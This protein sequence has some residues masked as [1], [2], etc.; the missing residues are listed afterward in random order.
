MTDV[1]GTSA[2]AATSAAYGVSP[3]A[4]GGGV[5]LERCAAVIYLARLLTGASGVELHG[6]RVERISCQQAAAHRVDDL[7]ISA[8]RDDGTD[9]LELDIAVRRAPAFTTGDQDTGKL[10]GDLLAALRASH[11]E[12]VELRLAICVA[13][14]QRAAQQVSHSARSP[15]SKRPR[16]G[17]STWCARHAASSR[18]WI[19]RGSVFATASMPVLRA[20]CSGGS[21]T[22]ARSAS[23]KRARGSP[24][25]SHRASG[26][27]VPRPQDRRPSSA[28]YRPMV[29]GGTRGGP[30]IS[31]TVASCRCGPA[32]GGRVRPAGTS[33]GTPVASAVSTAPCGP[34]P[35]GVRSARGCR[36]R[37]G[38]QW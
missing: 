3:Y 33:W 5:T 20:R 1:S 16:P 34:P 8:R 26:G 37:T 19:D 27:L 24:A 2:E 7:V 15:G 10:F 38:R 22:T 23:S 35:T 21:Q 29:A 31:R 32:R 30:L 25:G 17:S 14:P 28:Q 9:P 36:A 12:A 13:G 18:P 11:A 6:R 4:T